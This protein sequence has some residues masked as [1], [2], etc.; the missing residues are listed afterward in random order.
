MTRSATSRL[1][2]GSR[3]RSILDRRIRYDSSVTDIVSA[4]ASSGQATRPTS[5][6]VPAGR[7]NQ[8]AMAGAVPSRQIPAPPVASALASSGRSRELAGSG[9]AG[10]AA[11]AEGADV[12]AGLSLFA[13]ST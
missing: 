12:L 5:S 4:G 2:F 3:D 6:S 7:S 8:L 10:G 13:K 9:S 11:G 1:N